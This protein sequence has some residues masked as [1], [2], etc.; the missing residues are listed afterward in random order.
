MRRAARVVVVVVV[1]QKVVG[2]EEACTGWSC[3]SGY[4]GVVCVTTEMPSSS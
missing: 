1:V 4:N 3:T 2:C